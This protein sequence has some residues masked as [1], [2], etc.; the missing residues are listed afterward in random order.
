MVSYSRLTIYFDFARYAFSVP[1]YE[2]ISF[3]NCMLGVLLVTSDEDHRCGR[4]FVL[5]AKPK[6]RC[7]K[8]IG[9]CRTCPLEKQRNQNTSLYM[10]PPVPDCPWQNVSM[11]FVFGLSKTIRKH[12][13]IF[14][15]VDHFSKIAHFLPCSKTSDTFKISQIY[16]ME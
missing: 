12:D 16:L 2:T 4:K 14:V 3:V 11:D 6:M 9:Q 15:V 1:H 10:P 5:L 13:F 8:L 7:C